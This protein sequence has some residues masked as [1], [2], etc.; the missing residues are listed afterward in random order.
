MSE[1]PPVIG[2]A[3]T[4][5]KYVPRGTTEQVAAWLLAGWNPGRLVRVVGTT[6]RHGCALGDV[7]YTR[8]RGSTYRMP[9]EDFMRDFKRL[10]NDPP[11]PSDVPPEVPLAYRRMA[12]LLADDED[13]E[14]RP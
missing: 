3:W 6:E 2:E 10:P 14:V 9:V 4:D 5:A 1:K 13:D 7:H 8:G 12:E 11:D